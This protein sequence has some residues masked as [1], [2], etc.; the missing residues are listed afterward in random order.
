MNISGSTFFVTGASSGLGESCARRFHA[1]GG[2]VLMADLNRERGENVAAELG[3]RA[4]FVVTDVTSEESVAAAVN[5]AVSTFGGLSGAV[6][7]AGIVLG[8]RVLGR[9]APHELDAFARVIN[10]NLVGTFNVIRLVAA[11]MS[12][13]DAGEDGERGVIINTASCA[14]FEGQTG[15]AAYSASKAGVAGMTLPI[16]RELAKFGIRVMTIAPG[17]FDTPMMGGMTEEIRASLAAQ[18]PFPSR[19]G[20]PDEYAKLAEH[21]VSNRM[22]NGEVIRLDG[23]LRMGA[24]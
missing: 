11:Q 21:I 19:F 2:H 24:K 1:A 9:E 7:C 15:Q 12:K 3:E 22:L 20:H 6:N 23:A 14:A 4:R 17:T 16:A 10:V 13:Q 5:E 18:I 8:K